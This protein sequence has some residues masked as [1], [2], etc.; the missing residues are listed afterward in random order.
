MKNRTGAALVLLGVAVGLA[1]CDG[2]G[3]K[4]RPDHRQ[5]SR[6]CRRRCRLAPFRPVR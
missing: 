5:S 3:R 2:H 4:H 6:R 1:G